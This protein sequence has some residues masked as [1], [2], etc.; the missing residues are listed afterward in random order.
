[1]DDTLVFYMLKKATDL[2]NY[3]TDAYY[4]GTHYIRSL[5]C[6]WASTK[7]KFCGILK[8]EEEIDVTEMQ[9]GEGGCSG[10]HQADEDR[11]YGMEWDNIIHI[12]FLP[13]S[14]TFSHSI[15]FTSHLVY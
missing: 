14:Q 12:F 10:G 9:W 5:M 11:L 4:C 3:L 7:Y 8:I 13:F 2:T 6:S 15:S 1:M